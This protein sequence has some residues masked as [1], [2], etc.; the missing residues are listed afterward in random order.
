MSNLPRTRNAEALNVPYFRK[1][2]L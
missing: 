2:R 1:N